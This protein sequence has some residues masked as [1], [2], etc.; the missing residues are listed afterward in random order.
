MKSVLDECDKFNQH[1]ACDLGREMWNGLDNLK[2]ALGSMMS[3]SIERE[4]SLPNPIQSKTF[5]FS[6]ESWFHAKC[7]FRSIDSML[8]IHNQEYE[9]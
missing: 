5:H 8:L 4:G 6:S 7:L 1:H 3:K 2:L 9:G